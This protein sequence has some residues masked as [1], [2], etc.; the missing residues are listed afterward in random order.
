MKDLTSK[1]IGAVK[2]QAQPI[3]PEQEDY[4]WEHGIFGIDDAE[5]LINAVSPMLILTD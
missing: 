3:S 1:G 4:L 5:S 2:K